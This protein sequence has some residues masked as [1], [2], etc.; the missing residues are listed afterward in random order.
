MRHIQLENQYVS[1]LDIA[2]LKLPA[3]QDIT[4]G[5]L[6][7]TPSTNLKREIFYA[8]TFLLRARTMMPPTSNTTPITGDHLTGLF[9][10]LLISTGPKSTTFSLVT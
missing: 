4:E 1:K 2:R 3:K 8:P 9:F 10:S 5:V 7:Y 6:Y